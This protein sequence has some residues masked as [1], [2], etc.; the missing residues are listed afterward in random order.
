[1]RKYFFI[2]TFSICLAAGGFL[3]AIGQETIRADQIVVPPAAGILDTARIATLTGPVDVGV[4][5][6]A[7]RVEHIWKEI[8]H[9]GDSPHSLEHGKKISP[10]SFSTSVGT[11]F[12]TFP[13]HGSAM[14][15]FAD[16]RV[17]YAA[18]ERLGLHAGVSV[19]R[20]LP[21]T[22]PVNGESNVSQGMTSI[23][24]YVAASYMLTENLV[25]HGSGS[26]NALLMPVDGELQPIQFNDLSFGATYHFGNFS[27]GATIHRSDGPAFG[28]P[29]GSGYNM[30]GSPFYW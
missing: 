19:G 13:G 30:Y 26:R 24:T 22:G 8:D 6:I 10:W 1:M 27:I 17:N 7:D 9:A 4:L 16:P 12:S 23:S 20:I 18:T 15:M 5:D 11:S 14:A 21:F 25:L 29:F 28:A 2:W 3:P